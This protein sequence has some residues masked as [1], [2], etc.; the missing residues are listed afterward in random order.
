MIE[1]F[2]DYS[3]R[4]YERA[5]VRTISLELQDRFHADVNILLFLC[6]RASRGAVAPSLHDLA[7]MVE[8][9]KT[10]REQA[11]EPLRRLRRSL[12]KPLPHD[13]PDLREAF[14]QR[15][16]EAELAGE[17]LAQGI[18]EH[19]FPIEDRTAEA[20]FRDLAREALTRYLELIGT[21]LAWTWR[22]AEQLAE[23]A[24]DD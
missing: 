4:L 5:P 16:L 3:L 24:S 12:K 11:I 18:L 19:R 10:V 7:A 13:L 1:G 6:Y 22:S 21:P 14:R 9:V 20:P 8:A 23:A 17:A 15:V 2:W